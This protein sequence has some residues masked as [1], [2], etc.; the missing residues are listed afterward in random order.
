MEKE[1]NPT[2]LKALADSTRRKIIDL[3]KKEGRL[4]AGEIAAH[5]PLTQASISHHLSVLEK[6]RLIS[7][8]QEGKFIYYELNTTVLEDVLHWIMSLIGGKE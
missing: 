6:A 4:A 1:G 3:L 2:I 7:G 8:Q 5:F